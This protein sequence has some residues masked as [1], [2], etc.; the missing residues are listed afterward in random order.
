MFIKCSV[1][2]ELPAIGIFASVQIIKKY[3]KSCSIL[4]AYLFNR[5][6]TRRWVTLTGSSSGICSLSAWL[7]THLRLFAYTYFMHVFTYIDRY[8]NIISICFWVV[9]DTNSTIYLFFVL[10]A[11]LFCNTYIYKIKQ[12]KCMTCSN[13]LGCFRI[14]IHWYLL[15]LYVVMS[16]PRLK[17]HK[18][19][20]IMNRYLWQA[21]YLYVFP[22]GINCKNSTR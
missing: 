1:T 19:V 18:I 14:I 10:L 7:C 15:Q 3:W 21:D 2:R 22:N 20:C 17:G 5:L 6:K 12:I 16:A 9:K 8:T 4:L 11:W 13:C